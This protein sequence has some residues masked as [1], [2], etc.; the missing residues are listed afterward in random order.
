MCIQNN[1]GFIKE[2]PYLLI[3]ERVDKKINQVRLRR[4]NYKYKILS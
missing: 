2:K 3:I 1:I 4:K